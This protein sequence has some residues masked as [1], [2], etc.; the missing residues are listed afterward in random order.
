[1]TDIPVLDERALEEDPHAE[2]DRLARAQMTE[3][4]LADL[5]EMPNRVTFLSMDQ[6][7]EVAVDA[8]KTCDEVKAIAMETIEDG[9]ETELQ[10]QLLRRSM[11]A[12]Y[13][14]RRICLILADEF[15]RRR[16]GVAPRAKAMN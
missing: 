4:Q 3:K 10:A 2:Y 16:T 7:K 15:Q 12:E 6:L 1:M 13:L 5:E 8:R 11:A 14:W 9:V